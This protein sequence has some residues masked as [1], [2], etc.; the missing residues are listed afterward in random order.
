VSVAT[1]QDF[2][3]EKG[4]IDFWKTLLRNKLKSSRIRGIAGEM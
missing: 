2:A 4:K 1:F 3:I